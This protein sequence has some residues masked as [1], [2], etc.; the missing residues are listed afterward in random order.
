MNIQKKLQVGVFLLAFVTLLAVGCV[1]DKN[2]SPSQP[3]PG[4]VS[5]ET[6]GGQTGEVVALYF[7]DAG[8]NGLVK[9]EREIVFDDEENIALFVLEEL[10][11]GPVSP[12]LERTIPQGVRVVSITVEEGIATVDFSEELRSKHSGGSTGE[13]LTV[14]SIVNTLTGLPGLEKVKFLIEGK[15]LETLAGHMELS[16]PVAPDWNM[17]LD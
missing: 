11:K 9:E 8:A 14:Y 6:E 17:V 13:L 12:E 5:Q 10:L 16:E 2:P 7:A 3:S 1:L 15:E 4:E